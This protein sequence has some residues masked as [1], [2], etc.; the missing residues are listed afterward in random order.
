MVNITYG[1]TLMS[2]MVVPRQ[3]NFLVFFDTRIRQGV[4]FYVREGVIL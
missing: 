1:F 2:T 4:D 3:I